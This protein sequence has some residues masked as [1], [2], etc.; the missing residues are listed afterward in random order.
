VKDIVLLAGAWWVCYSCRLRDPKSVH[1]GNSSA[2]RLLPVLV[3]TSLWTVYR[4]C[5]AARYL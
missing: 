4:C 2:R 1:S 3:S 5:L